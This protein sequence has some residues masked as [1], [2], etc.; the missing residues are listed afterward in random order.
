MVRKWLCEPRTLYADD[1]AR[2]GTCRSPREAARKIDGWKV[3]LR[4]YTEPHGII[5][6]DTKLQILVDLQPD[7]PAARKELCDR[8][9]PELAQR[10]ASLA[11]HLG[12][13]H[14]LQGEARLQVNAQLVKA[15]KA[16]HA[17]RYFWGDQGIPLRVRCE[18]FCATVQT[19]TLGG[20]AT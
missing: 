15:G 19:R 10:C 6:N 8:L 2:M 20:L 4:M 11:Q 16:W 5:Q 3:S 13:V 7:T 17:T 14:A 1:L 9:G 12:C 18:V